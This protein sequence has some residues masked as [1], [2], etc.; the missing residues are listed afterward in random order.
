MPDDAP[1][2]DAEVRYAASPDVAWVE[3]PDRV[4]LVDLRDPASATPQLCP[5][6]AAS[7]WRAVAEGP[8]GESELVALATD[9]VGEQAEGLVAAF[10]EAFGGAGLVVTT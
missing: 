5:E 10:L 7:L 8:K 2:L 9:V 1:D 3:G 4:A 6:P